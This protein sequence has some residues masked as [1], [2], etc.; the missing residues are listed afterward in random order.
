MIHG[1]ATSIPNADIEQKWYD[2]LVGFDKNDRPVPDINLPIRQ[3]YGNL[4]E[5]GKVGL[6]IKQKQENSLLNV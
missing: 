3:K 5:S 2:S 6:L 4:N 1:L